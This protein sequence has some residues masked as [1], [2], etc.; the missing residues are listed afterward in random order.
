[1]AAATALLRSLRRRDVVSSSVTAFRSVISLCSSLSLLLPFTLIF[2]FRLFRFSFVFYSCQKNF[3]FFFILCYL[4]SFWLSL[5][6]IFTLLSF[7]YDF[8]GFFFLWRRSLNFDLSE[9]RFVIELS[10]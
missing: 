9:A 3:D 8:L 4:F 7:A 10:Y 6:E 2:S 1:M 5:F